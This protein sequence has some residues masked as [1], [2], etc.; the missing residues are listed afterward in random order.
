[1][2]PNV[3]L[4]SCLAALAL[5]VFAASASAEMAIA[6]D[7]AVRVTVAVQRSP[8]ALVMSWPLENRHTTPLPTYSVQRKDPGATSWG[9]AVA[10]GSTGYTDTGVAIGTTYEYRITAS[11][12]SDQGPYSGR[13][14]I[15]AGID[16]AAVHQR[17]TVVLI[18]GD[19]HA[20]AL[21]NELERLKRDLVGD[22]WK[23]IRHDVAPGADVAAI[24]Q[25]IIDDRAADPQVAAVY[26]FGRVPQAFSGYIGPDGHGGRAW[27]C[28]GYFGELTSTWPDTID[29]PAVAEGGFHTNEPGDGRFDPSSFPSDVELAVGRVALDRMWSFTTSETDLLRQYLDKTHAFRHRAITL[30]RASLIQDGFSVFAGGEAPASQAWQSTVS[31]GPAAT[32]ITNGLWTDY[33][34]SGSYLWAYACAGGG[35]NGLA[36]GTLT[37]Q[38]IADNDFGVGFTALF[39]SYFGD[40]SSDNNFMRAVLASRTYGLTCSWGGRPS[41]IYHR[42]GLGGTVGD[43]IK[44][45][46]NATDALYP[47]ASPYQRRGVHIAL[48]GDPTLTQYPVLPVGTVAATASA[49]RIDLTWSASPE[50]DLGYHVY[51]AASIDGPFTLLNATPTTATTYAD[52]GLAAGTHHYQVRAARLEVSPS[53]TFVNLSQG[54]FANA[55]IGGGGT[56]AGSTTGGTTAGTT[57][58]GTTSGGT[59]TSGTTTAGTTTAGTTTAGTTTAGTTTGGGGRGE[60]DTG[61]GKGSG[62]ATA[63][64]AAMLLLFAAPRGGR[65]PRA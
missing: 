31:V 47:V 30:A 8:P 63:L 6:R 62:F 51:R 17:G 60:N 45:S 54:A 65:R 23:V 42:M 55:T 46:Q 59:T 22:G 1:M 36:N 53:G 44:L 52:T 21:A 50:A 34:A 32:A 39:G 15:L 40:W 11:G 14:Y 56:T 2:H 10:G 48:M 19:L 38:L 35:Y 43:S 49:D 28:D 20:A 29:Y 13:A 7:Y 37:S 58:G 57:T 41:S 25:Q 16:V 33:A 61:C 5:A 9:P 4:K 18:V 24:R 3:R 27:P 12:T 64:A 26:L